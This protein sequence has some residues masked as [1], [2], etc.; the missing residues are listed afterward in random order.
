[1]TEAQ[2]PSTPHA[3]FD[4]PLRQSAPVA[5]PRTATHPLVAL[6]YT[7]RRI[8]YLIVAPV[9]GTALYARGASWAEW[10]G[11]AAHCLLWPHVAYY[12]A[13]SS[14]RS[15]EAER[16][17]ILIDAFLFGGWMAWLSFSL[18]P[19]TVIVSS[20]LLGFLG[21][22]G[23]R[24]TLIAVGPALAG[25]I[26]VGLVTGFRFEPGSS[27]LTT[28]ASVVCLLA[29]VIAFGL[30]TYSQ[31][32]K[33]IQ[34][35]KVSDEQRA[36]IQRVNALLEH[37]RAEAEAASGAK[38]QFLANMS[39][40]LRTPL[41][42]IIG[43]SEMLQE[44][45][46]DSGAEAMVADLEK[47]R[48][49]G[50]HLLGLINSVLDLSKIEAGKMQL[51]VETFD[52]ATVVREAAG[53][54]VPLA[55][56]NGNALEV[57]CAETLGTMRSD[58]TKV[59]QVLLNLLSNACKFTERGQVTLSVSRATDGSAVTFAVADTGMGMTR[60]QQDQLFDAFAL[61]DAQATRKHGGTGLGLALSRRLCTMMG[62]EITVQS[63]RGV[64][65]TF[66]VTL[67][68]AAP[69]MA[70]SGV[71]LPMMS[72]P[73]NPVVLPPDAVTPAAG[74]AGAAIPPLA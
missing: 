3:A 71:F 21:V 65:T 72:R 69:D 59:R 43:Y 47:I 61:I 34:T 27:N 13:K 11:L 74:R 42:A 20:L 15:K 52:V 40:E 16:R 30:I 12:W 2:H 36:H 60:E 19:S 4:A 70:Q 23:V 57:R 67:P 7:I 8:S 5:R 56:R 51:Y 33:L 22:G 31:A 10:L 54:A 35:R 24:L 63:E 25:A 18:W 6:D 26:A 53:T 41:N 73:S 44:E 62:G 45:A 39:H 28:A 29:Y 50:K 66:L 32:R 55:A 14:A 1:M 58:P 64:G 49:A 46:Q 9:I 37:A 68:A 48:G 17:N 38:S